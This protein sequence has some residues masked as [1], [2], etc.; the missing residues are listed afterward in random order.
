MKHK[1]VQIRKGILHKH[2]KVPVIDSFA[3]FAIL[4]KELG[5][6]VDETFH[7]LSKGIE[8]YL[9]CKTRENMI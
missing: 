9:G 3:D 7:V 4:P 8:F 6:T 1:I 5:L 2:V